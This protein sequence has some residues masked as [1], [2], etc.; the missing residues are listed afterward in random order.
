ML[1][2]LT[3]L[4]IG[5]A[6]TA[7]SSVADAI[8]TPG[9]FAAA[10]QRAGASNGAKHDENAAS[11]IDAAA[12]TNAPLAMSRTE[13]RRLFRD[14]EKSLA[15]LFAREDVDTSKAVRLKLDGAGGVRANSDHPDAAKIDALLAGDKQLSA[16]IA[17][18]LRSI[19]ASTAP[20]LLADIAPS[21]ASV[22]EP[23]LAFLDGA[24]TATLA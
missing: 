15:R 11:E 21:G 19:N 8:P 20:E 22:G 10:F 9:E 18:A 16:A 1:S 7:L 17:Q 6:A 14:V 24:L 2:V 5:A 3:P 4:S 12:K 23:A 13:L